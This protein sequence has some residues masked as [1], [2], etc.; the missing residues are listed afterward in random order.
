MPSIAISPESWKKLRAGDSGSYRGDSHHGTPQGMYRADR[1]PTQAACG[2][3]SNESPT[4][5]FA[6]CQ[7]IRK[8]MSFILTMKTNCVLTSN[9]KFGFDIGIYMKLDA[10]RQIRFYE[11]QL[12]LWEGVGM[13]L[14]PAGGR[15]LICCFPSLTGSRNV[16]FGPNGGG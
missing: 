14:P 4:G 16:K 3:Q 8:F 10:K 11:L 15:N 7:V 12:R 13:A 2:L 1:I 9:M 6:H 5:A